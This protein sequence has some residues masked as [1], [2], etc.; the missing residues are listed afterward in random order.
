M[1]AN[2]IAVDMGTT[3]TDLVWLDDAGCHMHKFEKPHP[4]AEGQIRQA[5]DFL[6]ERINKDITIGVTGGHYRT[7]PE[8]LDGYRLWKVDEMVALGVGGL[9]AAGLEAGLVVSAGTG[10]AMV[11]VQD[12]QA[13]HV[14]GSA[15]GGG[16]LLGL[17]NLVLGTTNI[18]EINQLALSGDANAVDIMISEAIGGEIGKLPIN[19]N[20]VNFGKL[21]ERKDFHRADLAA[22]LCRLVAQV[23]AVI[24]INASDAAGLKEIVLIGHTMDLS[25]IQNEI[26]MVGAFYKR[27]FFM[28]DHPG[29]ATAKGVIHVMKNEMAR[30]DLRL[31]DS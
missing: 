2:L 16:T 7:L 6:G 17:S 25:A 21:I 10:T 5:I 9:Q 14:T 31:I 28:P 15:V 11:A 23:I 27:N 18:D 13:H 24:A 22:G 29:F 4:M 12:G 8:I 26:K 20:A 1:K 19:A 3:N 30:G